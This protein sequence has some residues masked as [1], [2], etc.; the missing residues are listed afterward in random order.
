MRVEA[1]YGDIYPNILIGANIVGFNVRCCIGVT[2][3]G[4]I[5]KEIFLVSHWWSKTIEIYS[6][7]IFFTYIKVTVC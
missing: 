3:W 4:E 1:E 7:L 5:G 2:L 6:A